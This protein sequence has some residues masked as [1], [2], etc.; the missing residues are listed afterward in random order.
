VAGCPAPWPGPLADAVVAA[1]R[2]V[3]AAAARSAAA[4][5]RQVRAAQ[6]GPALVPTRQVRAAQP[7]P[8]PMP[9]R[10]AARPAPVAPA[11]GPAR[12]GWPAELVAV[13]GR[14]LPVTG[15]TDYAAALARLADT[16]NCPAPWSSALRRAA[17][18]IALRRAFLKEIR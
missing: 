1:L 9:T 6:P 12:P 7:V 18:A 13:A 11:P 3:V 2:H 17:E 15:S 4:A 16:D 5:A 14:G 8:A 10:Q